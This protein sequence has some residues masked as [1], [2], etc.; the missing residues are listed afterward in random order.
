MPDLILGCIFLFH[1][2]DEYHVDDKFM[3]LIFNLEGLSLLPRVASIAFIGR[4]EDPEAEFSLRHIFKFRIAT[5]QV[6]RCEFPLVRFFGDPEDAVGIEYL[7]IDRDG[8]SHG[9]PIMDSLLL[10]W[11]FRLRS[12]RVSAYL[13]SVTENLQNSQGTSFVVRSSIQVQEEA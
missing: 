7:C 4:G 11:V 3:Y 10:L 9:K 6:F 1:G 5:R 12:D 13:Q 2:R 8:L